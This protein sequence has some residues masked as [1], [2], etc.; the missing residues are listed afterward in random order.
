[1][2]GDEFASKTLFP[3]HCERCRGPSTTRVFLPRWQINKQ[4]PKL[5]YKQKKKRKNKKTLTTTS[6]FSK[7]NMC[8]PE[9]CQDGNQGFVR[10]TFIVYKYSQANY[11]FLIYTAFS[12]ASN[13]SYSN[14][15]VLD[16]QR[17]QSQH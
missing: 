16:I 17:R 14:R 2:F 7:L 9:M 10:C 13:E 1:M 12:K 6:K 15:A 8:N 3:L 5:T 4:E 11:A